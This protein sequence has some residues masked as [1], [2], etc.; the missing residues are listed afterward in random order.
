MPS[1]TLWEIAKAEVEKRG[2]NGSEGDGAEIA[3]KSV[4]F[5]GSKNGSLALS[6]RLECSGVISAH[7][8]LRLLGSHHSP[9][10]ASQVAGTA[11]AHDHARERLLLF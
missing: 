6:S 11:A 8:S 5:I 9:A 10:S 4:F 7:C 2:I 1:E 3:E